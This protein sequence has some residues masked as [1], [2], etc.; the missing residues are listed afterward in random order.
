MEPI[1]AIITQ[2]LVTLQR[3]DALLFNIITHTG[4]HQNYFRLLNSH[5]CEFKAMHYQH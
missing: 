3:Q 5:Q 1:Y 4:P 2:R